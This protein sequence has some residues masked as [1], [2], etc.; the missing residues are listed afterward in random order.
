MI[1]QI[2]T[3]LWPFFDLVFVVCFW[4]ITFDG[5]HRF[6]SNFAEL[7]FTVKYRSSAV[8]VIICQILA[9]LWPFFDLVF[10]GVLKLVSTQ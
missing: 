8:L 10:V 5:M 6:H 2:L 4:S 7:Y 1:S 9:E 3:E